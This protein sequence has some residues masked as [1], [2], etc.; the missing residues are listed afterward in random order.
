MSRNPVPC[1][2]SPC[3]ETFRDSDGMRKHLSKAHPSEDVSTVMSELI[4]RLD[5]EYVRDWSR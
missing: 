3:R 4:F 2:I 1:P 5:A